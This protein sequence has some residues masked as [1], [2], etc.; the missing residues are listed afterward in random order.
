MQFFIRAAFLSLCFALAAFGQ[1]P[2]PAPPFEYF[3]GAQYDAGVPTLQQVTGHAVGERITLHHEIE[4]YVMALQQAAP[5]RVKV[6]KYAETWEGRA[7]Y[8]VFIGSP[9]N[10]ARLDEIQAAMQRLSDPRKT[11][12]NEANQ[13]IASLPSIVWLIPGVHGNEISSVDSAL[14]TAYHLLA[15][16]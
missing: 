12:A 13:L 5:A 4:R 1:T 3:P 15:A 16:R 6:M 7:L 9:E 8:N 10:I 11:N 2:A 14:Q